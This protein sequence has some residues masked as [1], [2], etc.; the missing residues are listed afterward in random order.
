MARKLKRRKDNTWVGVEEPPEPFVVTMIQPSAAGQTFDLP[1]TVAFLTTDNSKVAKVE[2]YRT[3]GGAPVKLGETSTFGAVG[4]AIDLPLNIT[5]GTYTLFGRANLKAG[6]TVD[7]AQRSAT[8]QNPG[9]PDVLTMLQPSASGQSLQIPADI[10]FG[11]SD[12]TRVT[13]VELYYGD[14]TFGAIKWGETTVNGP[15]G[16][17]IPVPSDIGPG[18]YE[19]WGKGTYVSGPSVDSGHRT[20]TLTPGPVGPGGSA[21][22]KEAIGFGTLSAT[23]A[24]SSG[25]F[26]MRQLTERRMGRKIVRWLTFSA[27]SSQADRLGDVRG[28]VDSIERRRNGDRY[29]QLQSVYLCLN[30]QTLNSSLDDSARADFEAIGRELNRLTIDDLDNLYAMRLGWEFNGGWFPHG[31]ENFALHGNDVWAN[32]AKFANRFRIAVDAMRSQMSADKRSRLRIDWAF[33]ALG[34]IQNRFYNNGGGITSPGVNRTRHPHWEV[35][36]RCFP[37][38]SYVTGISADMYNSYSFRQGHAGSSYFAI[39]ATGGPLDYL[40]R[41]AITHGVKTGMTEGSPFFFRGTEGTFPDSSCLD[42]LNRLLDWGADE[43]EA[44]RLEY[45]FFFERDKDNEGN[46]ASFVGGMDPTD[47]LFIPYAERNNEG[48]KAF[49]P[50]APARTGTQVP[51]NAPDMRWSNTAARIARV[52]NG[53]GTARSS[54]PNA[55]S[56]HGALL[57]LLLDRVGGL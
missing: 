28:A 45:I 27:R 41:R 17:V 25:T 43:A 6:G 36:D 38:P 18:T 48:W 56:N 49:Y 40:T 10:A 12:P 7:S 22:L 33:S 13:K 24:F 50:G 16:Y 32:A 52:Y 35:L 51:S 54:T 39:D 2:L 4:W 47:K 37:G 57:N 1:S 20:V 31:I 5:P 8:Y 3:T 42:F 34:G 21:S 23:V 9:T 14:P 30:G 44:G 53:P 29:L 11:A 55:Q 19:I 26:S 15:V 46:F